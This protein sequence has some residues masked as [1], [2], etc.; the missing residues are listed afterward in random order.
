MLS[1][2]CYMLHVTLIQTIYRALLNSA[3]S[4][5][6]HRIHTPEKML[7]AKESP[8]YIQILL[9]CPLLLNMKCPTILNCTLLGQGQQNTC[10][11]RAKTNL[12]T[13]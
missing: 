12:I 8:A 3:V 1:A 4:G 2:E 11:V 13:Y 7:S 10:R 5:I 9:I 6:D